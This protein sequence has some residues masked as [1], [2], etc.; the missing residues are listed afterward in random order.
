MRISERQVARLACRVIA[1]VPVRSP[2]SLLSH[3]GSHI[4][5]EPLGTNTFNMAQIEADD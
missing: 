3:G 2:F 4:N 5:A 1:R